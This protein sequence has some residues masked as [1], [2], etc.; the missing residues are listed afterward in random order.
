MIG[1]VGMSDH[2]FMRILGTF[3]AWPRGAGRWV[4]RFEGLYYAAG[5]KP[6]RT[7]AFFTTK[8][9]K[10]HRGCTKIHRPAQNLRACFVGLVRAMTIKKGHRGFVGAAG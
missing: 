8:D 5:D 7:T 2:P 1:A 4:R 6:D 3:D 9:S 10:N